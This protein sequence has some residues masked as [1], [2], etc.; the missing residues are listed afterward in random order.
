MTTSTTFVKDSQS[1]IVRYGIKC[2]QMI[3][4]M[5]CYAF[6][7]ATKKGNTLVVSDNFSYCIDAQG[8]SLNGTYKIISVGNGNI[9]PVNCEK[10]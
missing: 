2:F 7:H 9:A 6:A 5:R 1:R 10:I 8:N 4:G 3:D